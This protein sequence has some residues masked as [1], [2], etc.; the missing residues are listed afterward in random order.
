MTNELR[1]MIAELGAVERRAADLRKAILEELA[2]KPCEAFSQ[3][4][5][6]VDWTRL[7]ER[8]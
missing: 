7:K 1:D 5:L 6:K 2:T 4:F 3:G 8:A